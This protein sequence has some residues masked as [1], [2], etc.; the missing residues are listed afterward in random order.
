M[1]ETPV[2]SNNECSNAILLTE[3][4]TCSPSSYNTI[5][6]TQSLAG[7]VG[8]ADDDVWFE[9]VATTANPTITVVSSTGFNAVIDL[10]SGVCNGTNISCTN[11]T[12]TSGTETLVSSG[13]TIGN[14][15]YI[16]VYHYSSGI[17]GGAF[18][19]CVSQ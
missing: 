4:A 13:L 18:T 2:P 19:I 15:Y 17:G 5:G 3:N 8:N 10:R 6:A 7:C 16:R 12:G 1:A 14:T 9:F 11:A